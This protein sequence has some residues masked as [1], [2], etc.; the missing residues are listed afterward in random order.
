MAAS[1]MKLEDIIAAERL[2]QIY[3]KVRKET[4]LNQ[5][6]LSEK[7]GMSQSNLAIYINGHQP[8]SLKILLRLAEGLECNCSDIRPEIKDKYPCLDL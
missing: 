5:T 6:Q 1:K 7:I 2:K 3:L 4:G 8:I